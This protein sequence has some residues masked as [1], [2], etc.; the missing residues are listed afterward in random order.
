MCTTPSYI[1]NW[2]KNQLLNPKNTHTVDPPPSPPGLDFSLLFSFVSKLTFSATRWHTHVQ[3]KQGQWRVRERERDVVLY[4][5]CTGKKADGRGEGG[6]YSATNLYVGVGSLWI[7]DQYNETRPQPTGQMENNNLI[8]FVSTCSFS[9]KTKW[10]LDTHTRNGELYTT[11]CNRHTRGGGGNTVVCC[12]CG[13]RSK[14]A[15]VIEN[16]VKLESSSERLQFHPPVHPT[17]PVAFVWC[18]KVLSL[19]S[20]LNFSQTKKGKKKGKKKER[21][22]SSCIWNWFSLGPEKLVSFFVL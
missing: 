5:K 9:G 15:Q 14:S 17:L 19:E 7:K 10:T 6:G 2:L 21:K 3:T 22:V 12:K 11:L 8:S 1:C 20:G 18:V 4:N 16:D 13:G